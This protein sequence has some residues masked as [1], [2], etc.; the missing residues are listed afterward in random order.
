MNFDMSKFAELNSATKYPSILTYHAL[1]ERGMLTEELTTFADVDLDDPSMV[2]VTEKVD[3]TNGRIVLLPGGD[4]FIGSREELLYAKGDRVTKQCMPEPTAIVETLQPIAEKLCKEFVVGIHTLYVEVFGGSIARNAKQYS[5][6]GRVSCRL[7]DVSYAP[8]STL[9]KE[10][11]EIALWRD[12]GGQQWFD[13]NLLQSVSK[14]CNIPMVPYLDDLVDNELPYSV[15]D[16]Y[17]WLK[18][19][20]DETYVGLDEKAGGRPEGLVIRDHNRTRIAKIRFQDYAR[21]LKRRQ[22]GK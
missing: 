2:Y 9:D 14:D 10:R 20:I 11:G 6:T 3:G 8:L 16:T 18:E 1:G 19:T 4:Y 17:Q 21:T 13:V 15:E 12:N 5:G 7:F 22:N